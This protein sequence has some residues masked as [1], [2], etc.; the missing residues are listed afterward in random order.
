MKQ[1]L[2]VSVVIPLYNRAHTIKR[3]VDSVIKQS[4]P[5]DE[6]V[7]VDDGSTDKTEEVVAA[8]GDPRI[9]YVKLDRNCGAQAAR[10][11]GIKSASCDLISFIDS[12]DEW[13]PDKLRLEI[14][15]LAKRGE[16]HVVHCGAWEYLEHENKKVIFPIPKL[17]GDVY[18]TLLAAPG[19]VFPSLLAKRE[20]FYKIGFLDEKVPS[21]QEWD[22]SISLAKYYKFAYVDEPLVVYHIHGGEMIS[23][24]K[25]RQAEGWRYVVE[26]H[27]NEMLR[28]SGRTILASHYHQIGMFYFSAGRYPQVKEFLTKAFLNDSLNP[29]R[30][31]VAGLSLVGEG[32]FRL[33][34]KS[35]EVV[36]RLFRSNHTSSY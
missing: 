21:Y 29:L 12:D 33:A 22:T 20:C 5:P 26:K 15:E 14:A 13:L 32:P 16:D 31:G 3:C 8:I 28:V 24:N 27:R 30:A 36:R 6:I 10:N 34:Y 4:L 25:L 2:S 1:R 7:L 35:Y 23:K 17:D 11:I 18:K 9:R 19:P